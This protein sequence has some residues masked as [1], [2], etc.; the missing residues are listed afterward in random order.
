MTMD[1][2]TYSSHGQAMPKKTIPI[3]ENAFEAGEE[4]A[5]YWLGGAGVLLNIHGT[6]LMIDP[7]LRGFDMPLLFTPPLMPEEVLKL[8]GL[9]L[10]HI[11]NDHFGKETC[12]ALKGICAGVYAPKYVAEEVG[13]LG[14]PAHGKGIGER[15][16]VGSVEVTLTPAWH[17]WQEGIPE[18]SYRAWSREDY[19]G[20]R[21]ETPDG[22][23][24]MPGDSKLLPEQ[25]TQ[26]APDLILFDFSDNDWHITFEGAVTLAN[27]YPNADL[28]CIHWG[29]VDAPE[30][31]PFNGEPNKL[32]TRV[33]N[34]ER[35]LA[36]LPGEKY[37][38]KKK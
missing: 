13:K 3:V 17:N 36:L 2:V 19:C 35:L 26:P 28:L 21:I 1:S 10:T 29:T 5:I 20:F 32:L 15:F 25:L 7:V 8:D 16:T 9:L 14:L 11:D 30:M 33:V 6:I 24:W 37:A 12:A 31:T 18:F 27:A 23:I 34:P 4:T 38:L 22:S